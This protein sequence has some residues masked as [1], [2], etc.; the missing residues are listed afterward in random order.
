MYR[1]SCLAEFVQDLKLD[2]IEIC[3]G[4]HGMTD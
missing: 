2:V 3:L 1:G 4:L